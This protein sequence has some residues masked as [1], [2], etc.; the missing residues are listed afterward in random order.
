MSSLGFLMLIF[1]IMS[2]EN[3]QGSSE[4]GSSNL[5][6]LLDSE[7]YV[8]RLEKTGEIDTKR[9]IIFD[10]KGNVYAK[11]RMKN[12]MPLGPVEYYYRAGQLRMYEHYDINSELRFRIEF[13]SL[14]NVSNVEGK[15]MYIKVDKKNRAAGVKDTIKYYPE[16]FIPGGLIGKL[17]I[18]VERGSTRDTI[19]RQYLSDDRAPLFTYVYED[20]ALVRFTFISELL[21]PEGSSIVSDTVTIMSSPITF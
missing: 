10:K 19:I 16:L 17:S 1:M 11:F 20:S 8:V 18:Y 9:V 4:E 2:C 5:T 12:E 6:T 21:C 15:S 13:D 14:F 3:P 7:N